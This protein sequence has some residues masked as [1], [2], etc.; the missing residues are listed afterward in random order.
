[1]TGTIGLVEILVMILAGRYKK[2]LLSFIPFIAAIVA[3]EIS[4][5]LKR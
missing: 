3:T 4:M 1:M 5:I 2:E